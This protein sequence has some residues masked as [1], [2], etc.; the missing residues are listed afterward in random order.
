MQNDWSYV[1]NFKNEIKKLGKL[2]GNIT[3]VT[4]NVVALYSSITHEDGLE[5][6]TERLVQ[7]EVFKLPVNNIATM[8]EFCSQE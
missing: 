8:G 5:T 3:L 4:A 2:S 1:N 7:S 6:L